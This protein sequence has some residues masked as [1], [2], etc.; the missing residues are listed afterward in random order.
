MPQGIGQELVRIIQRLKA[1]GEERTWISQD[2]WQAFTTVRP[3]TRQPVSV[4][5]NPAQIPSRES[6]QRPAVRVSQMAFPQEAPQVAVPRNPQ[7]PVTASAAG[8]T[9]TETR[10]EWMG[11]GSD[12]RGIP[13]V[14]NPTTRNLNQTGIPQAPVTPME[15]GGGC[16]DVSGM[17]WDALVATALNCRGCRLCEQRRH[18]VIEDGCRRA[19]VMFIGEGP[20]ESE[21]IQGVP[22]VGRAGQ[23]LTRMIAAMGLDRTSQDPATAAYIANIVKCRPPR[24]RNPEVDE[25]N[26]CLGYLRRQIELVSPKVIVLLGAVPLKFLMGKTGITA[27]RGHWLEYNGIPVMPTFHPAHILRFEVQRERFIEEKRKVWSDLQQVMKVMK[28]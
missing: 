9:A 4:S 14:Q 26:A 6:V 5:N 11:T 8:R 17:D 15:Q 10:M 28:E 22:F 21:D 24:N 16:A 7:M 13:Q 2:N 1:R 3:L 19:R 27:A 20:G 25:G 23:L 12:V 18:V